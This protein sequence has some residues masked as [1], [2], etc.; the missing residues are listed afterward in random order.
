[1]QLVRLLILRLKTFV[2]WMNDSIAS[3]DVFSPRSVVS[4][5]TS[6]R[7]MRFFQLNT[8]FYRDARAYIAVSSSGP[9]SDCNNTWPIFLRPWVIIHVFMRYNLRLGRFLTAGLM[10][11]APLHSLACTDVIVYKLKAQTSAPVLCKIFSVKL[12]RQHWTTATGNSLLFIN[13]RNPF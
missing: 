12:P 1:M 13:H 10:K 2:M 6:A 11:V 5:H 8:S 3:A 9:L 7:P 4:L